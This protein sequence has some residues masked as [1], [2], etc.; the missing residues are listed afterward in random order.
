MEVVGIK[1][2]YLLVMGF[3]SGSDSKESAYNE[4]DPGLVPGW[5]RYP[6]DENGYPL[7]YSCLE[8]PIVR[9]AQQ[10]MVYEVAKNQTRLK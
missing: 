7:R 5:E 6:G 4:G 3:A 2:R 10:A 9:G 8:N 1:V